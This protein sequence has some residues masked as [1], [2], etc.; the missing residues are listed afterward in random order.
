WTL[1]AVIRHTGQSDMEIDLDPSATMPTFSTSPDFTVVH[2][3]G[4]AGGGTILEGGAVDTIR[5]VVDVTGSAP[6]VCQANALVAGTEIN[7]GRALVPATAASPD[8]AT[9]SIQAP[10]ALSVTAISATQDPVTIAQARQWSIEA[11][12]ENTGGSSLAIDFDDLDSTVVWIPGGTGFAFARPTQLVGGGAAL[13]AGGSGTMRFTVTTTGTAGPG[14]TAL[15]GMAIGTEDNSGRRVFGELIGP[16]GVNS[17]R[18]ESRPET[19]YEAGTL[20]PSVASSGSD[21]GITLTIAGGDA[22]EATLLLD[23]AS[24]EAWFG[25]ADGDTFRTVLSPVSPV[26]LAGGGT[27]ALIFGSGTIPAAL[28]RTSY[29]VGIHL[30]GTE[31][32]NPFSADLS[33]APDLITIEEAPQLSITAIE[34][35]ASV[36]RGLQ[37]PWEARMILRNTGEASV[38]VDLDAAAT[39]IS[40]SIAGAGDVTGEYTI[41]PPTGLAAAGG[42]VLAGNMTDTLV[43]TVASTGTTSG[44]ALIN[45]QVEAEDVNSGGRV[46]DDTYPSGGRYLLVQ[47]PAAPVIVEAAASRE[48][49]TS[50]QATPW[51]LTLLVRNDGEAALTLAP[52][53]ARIYAAYGLA[54]P[55]PPAQFVEGGTALA[56]GQSRH[57]AFE[58]SPTPE[59]GPAGLDLRID[60]VAGF[61]EDNRGA[62]LGFDTGVAGSGYG[63]VLVQTPPA[64]RIVSLAGAAPRTP[65]VNRGQRFRID[66][67]I[68]NTGEAEADQVSV[69]LEAGGPSVVLDAPFTLGPIAGGGSA[70]GSFTVDAAD[71]SGDETFSAGILSAVDVNSGQAGLWTREAALDSTETMTLQV[72]GALAVTALT[73]SQA[74]VNA[75]QTSD[76]ELRVDLANAGEAPVTLE[77]PAAGDIAFRIPPDLFTDYLVIAPAGFASGAPGLTLPGGGF[78]SL[79]YTVSTTGSDTGS[80]DVAASARWIDDNDPSAGTSIS[81]GDTM[82]HVREPSGLRIILVE[83]DAPND[84]TYPNTSIVNVDQAFNVTVTVENTGGD[85]LTSVDV[86]LGTNGSAVIAPVSGTTELP[87]GSHAEYVYEVRSAVDGVEILTASIVHAVSVNTGR[88]V[89]PIQAVESIENLIVQVPADLAV[90]AFISA[91]G[92]AADDTLSTG[93]LFDLTAVVHNLGQASIDAAGQITLTLPAGM[94]REYPDADSLTRS[95]AAGQELTWTIRADAAPSDIPY[96]L[97]SAITRTPRDVNIASEAHVQTLSAQKNVV[98][99][100]AASIEVC[101]AQIESPAGAADRVLSTGQE[102]VF[103]ADMIPSANSS[104]NTV[105]IVVP[106]GFDLEGPATLVLGDGDGEQRTMRWTM[107]APDAHVDSDSIGFTTVGTDENSGLPLDGCS[108]KLGVRVVEKAVLDLGAEISGPAEAVGGQ[109]SVNLQF[110]IEALVSNG[111]TAGIDTTGARL[112]LVLPP[113]PQGWSADD[114]YSLVSDTYHKP[115][116]PGVPVTWNLRAASYPA[117]PGNITVRFYVQPADDE[118]SNAPAQALRTEIQIPVSTEAGTITMQ[119]VSSLDTIPPAVVPQGA[120]DVPVLRVVFRNNSAYTAGLDTVLVSVEDARGRLLPNPSRSVSAVALTA[121]GEEYRAAVGAVNP[122]PVAVDGAF[123]ISPGANDTALVSLDIAEGAPAGELRIDLASSGDVRF[124][125]DG[126]TVRVVWDESG[127]DI[128]GHFISSPMSVM[129]ADF[130][131]YVHNYPNPFRAGSETTRIAYFLTEDSSVRI[132]IFDFTGRLVWTKEI[133]AGGTGGTGVPEGT[134][135][136][137]EWDGRNGVGEVVRNGV[138]V[139]IVEAGGRSA[140]F[141][142]AVAK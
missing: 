55:A 51:T 56:G 53:S 3:A 47:Q 42:T 102:L 48:R 126:Q 33:S 69:D 18:F 93:Q 71:E 46:T 10:A 41:L 87:S 25:D 110:S 57:L 34:A 79:I 98:V 89:P 114:W 85:D 68:E 35:P 9:I 127:G 116:R 101:A 119:N 26:S 61:F 60:A 24:T 124:S 39:N 14:E 7:S 49:V 105:T 139:C 103:R 62:Y 6:G 76:W 109:L 45:G 21:I 32:G 70:A 8:A 141:K 104:D 73:P 67:E 38:D 75:G 37:P 130:E 31:N 78:D 91:P 88:E 58:I 28:D 132:R 140:Q 107:T 137:I 40:I 131:E 136:E 15:A 5:F 19:R 95:F 83:S 106:A 65:Y 13:P 112:E 120:R 117:L 115:Y 77:T 92:G 66:V 54:V 86:E 84:A 2:P 43:F 111:G 74:E 4:L 29:T 52:D 108:F 138:Y 1:Q 142:M 90:E 99:E 123:A 36:T 113:L 100:A 17:V 44:T 97:V 125:T 133:P 72:P 135:W 64:L 134:W 96:P 50:G 30:E 122:V 81:T 27:A 20:S 63:S 59:I 12:I 16:V 118:N 94:I 82:V 23:R 22:D 11:E 129:S 80:V 121:G 128:A